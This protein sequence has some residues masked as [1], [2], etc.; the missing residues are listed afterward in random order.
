MNLPFQRHTLWSDKVLFIAWEDIHRAMEHC[1]TRKKVA[2]SW[3]AQAPSAG[4]EEGLGNGSWCAGCCFQQEEETCVRIS[5][6]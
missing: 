4:C 3:M 5:L 1:S 2:D 6:E